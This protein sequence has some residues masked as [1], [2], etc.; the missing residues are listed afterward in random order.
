MYTFE[1]IETGNHKKDY[2]KISCNGKEIIQ[3]G[4]VIPLKHHEDISSFYHHKNQDAITYN[5]ILML[6][7]RFKKLYDIVKPSHPEDFSTE[8]KYFSHGEN[9]EK[10]SVNSVE[11]FL[12]VNCW[13]VQININYSKKNCAISLE[14]LVCRLFFTTEELMYFY[15]ELLKLYMFHYKKNREE[16]DKKIMEKQ[17]EYEK[18][19][20]QQRDLREEL[21]F[22]EKIQ[23]EEEK[24]KCVF[25]C[26]EKLKKGEIEKEKM[27]KQK[28]KNKEYNQK[29]NIC[30]CD[31]PGQYWNE[32]RRTSVC[33]KCD[34]LMNVL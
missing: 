20:N 9:L 5:E 34:K 22:I 32:E 11:Y 10:D 18:I 7:M 14:G 28:E 16:L 3:I 1:A 2:I 31:I 8:K 13:L 21:D 24:D 19:T 4:Y 6:L 27:R 33:H 30:C 12:G 23:E 26:A 17:G 25:G 29:R 15:K